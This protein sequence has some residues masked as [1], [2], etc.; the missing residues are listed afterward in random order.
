MTNIEMF[1]RYERVRKS[2]KYNM[3]TEAVPAMQE[4]GL[5][6]D[7]YLTVMNHYSDFKAEYEAHKIIEDALKEEPPF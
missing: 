5:T 7:E 3:I 1:E 4:A 6:Q 2:G